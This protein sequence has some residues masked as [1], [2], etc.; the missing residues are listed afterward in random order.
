MYTDMYIDIYIY[1]YIYKYIYIYIYIDICISAAR[2]L[3]WLS[4]KWRRGRIRPQRG[5]GQVRG[6]YRWAYAPT[7]HL[8]VV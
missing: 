5:P 4:L 8:K 3:A 1:I 2:D 7:G 6:S